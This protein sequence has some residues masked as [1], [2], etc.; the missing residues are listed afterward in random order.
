MMAPSSSKMAPSS[1]ITA[2]SHN[3]AAPSSNMI[4][5]FSDDMT[6]LGSALP[7]YNNM[8]A[9]LA[10]SNNIMSSS[11]DVLTLPHQTV[12]SSR[13]VPDG[14]TGFGSANYLHTP[15]PNCVNSMEDYSFMN[16]NNSKIQWNGNN[17]S[18]LRKSIHPFHANL[19]TSNSS[20]S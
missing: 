12:S 13:N 5:P 16:S 6:S 7:S 19:F 10:T 17:V 1:N 9:P 14:I 2:P 4:P 8:M 18:K 11:H 20:K 3:M 15:G